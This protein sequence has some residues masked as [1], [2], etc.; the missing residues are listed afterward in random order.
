[1]DLMAS[2]GLALPELAL[3]LGAI[4]FLLIG[5]FQGDRSLPGISWGAAVLLA[6]AALY[7]ADDSARASAFGGLYVA[8]RFGAFLKVVI[9][10]AAAAAAILSLPWL[11]RTPATARFEFPILLLFG[12]LGMGLM[13]SAS[14]LLTL[15]IGLEL[16][17]LAA[18]VLASFHRH[19]S[20]SAEAG[21]KYFVLGALA[22]GILLFGASL[23]YGFAG[24]TSFAGLGEAIQGQPS[25]GALV[26]MVFVLVGL[27]FKISAVP[28]HMWTPDVYEGAPTPVVAFFAAA[29]KVAAMGLLARV[30]VEAFGGASE[31]WRQIVT[32]MAIASMVLGALAAIGQTSIKRLLAYSSINNVGFALIGLAAGSQ[33]GLSGLLFYMAVYAAMT[34]GAFA[35]LLD[36]RDLDG[37][38]VETIDGLA[39]LARARPGIALA[40]AIF[41]FSLAGIPPLLGFW[42][43]FSVFQ[44]AV[45]AGMWPLAVIGVIASVVAAYYY[46]R[47]VKTMYFDEAA[48]PVAGRQS[49]AGGAVIAAAALFCSPLGMLLIPALVG[50]A[51]AA[52]ASLG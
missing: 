5:V 27:A 26:G 47:I 41:M 39:G 21:M 23:V 1:M 51:R 43:K 17:S 18:Y 13:V 34:I 35:V 4:L 6:G 49:L 20:R 15:Y 46:L 8:D 33:A 29:P 14:D 19:D 40:L 28:F 2:L 9:L 50:A 32:V 52:A 31:A 11:K 48:V 42:P 45:E 12:A 30:A 7:L 25:L 44:A 16:Q 37:R 10:L 36:L 3:G 38:P 22:S 24:T